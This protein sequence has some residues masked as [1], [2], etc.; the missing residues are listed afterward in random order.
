MAKTSFFSDG[1][2]HNIDTQDFQG[3]VRTLDQRNADAI[4]NNALAVQRATE[5]LEIMAEAEIIADATNVSTTANKTAAQASQAAAL[6]SEVAAQ[7]HRTAAAASE[8]ASATSAATASTKA[9]EAL[10]S[11]STANTAR[12][13]TLAA[14]DVTTG[15]RDTAVTKAADASTSA[16][17]A[18]S[19]ANQLS[20]QL[21]SFNEVYLGKF[22]AAPTLDGNG[23][24]LKV[25]AMYE[26]TTTN[27]LYV[28][29]ADLTWHAYDESAQT[30]TT[31]AALSATNAAGSAAT[32]TASKDTA[33]TQAGI[34]TTKAGEAATSATNAATSATNAAGSATTS[35]TKAGE[36]ATSATNAAN[37]ATTAANT[38]ASKAPLASPQFTGS[39][40]IGL[41]ATPRK[42][43]L[44][45]AQ[46][47]DMVIK[48][49]VASG[50]AG[51]S[52]LYFG[53]NTVDGMGWL[54][55]D[56]ALNS[57]AFATNAG[58]AMRISGA[59]NLLIG[60][61]ADDGASKLQVAGRASIYGAFANA[62]GLNVATTTADSYG[63][64]QVTGKGL[65]GGQVSLYRDTTASGGMFGDST[66]LQLYYNAVGYSLKLASS[67]NVLVGTTTDAGQRLQVIG[68]AVSGAVAKWQAGTDGVRGW[69]Y[70][71]SDGGG[72]G[73]ADLS[74]GIGNGIY[75]NTTGN[76]VTLQTVGSE[77]VR[78]TSG[79]NVL[80]GTT[81][82]NG[83]DKLQ[84][85]GRG[86]FSNGS[87]GSLVLA[88]AFSFSDVNYALKLEGDTGTSGGYLSQ[89]VNVGGFQLSQGGTYYGG[90]PTRTDANSTSFSSI[91][92][93]AGELRF[94]TNSALSVNSNFT[95]A[96][97][98]RINTFG[99]LGL[100]T[101]A[102][103]KYNHGGSARVLEIANNDTAI[104]SQAHLILNS[105]ATM[106]STAIGTMS[107][108]MP[109][110][111]NAAKMMGY[112]GCVTDATHTS[113]TPVAALTFAVRNGGSSGPYEAMRLMANGD[114]KMSNSL[115]VG[116]PNFGGTPGFSANANGSAYIHNAAQANG[117]AWITV[118]RDGVQ[119]GSIAQ[120]GTTGTVYNTTSDYRLKFQQKPLV[121]SGSF[122][123]ALAPKTWVW[124]DGSPGTGFI[125]HEFQAVSPAS[126]TGEK[127]AVDDEGKP[128]YQAMQ[129]SS[130]E[131]MANIIAELQSLRLRVAQLE[132]Q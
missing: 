70:L 113:A 29:Q 77:R 128:K 127:D 119:L 31:N 45:G 21:Y 71:Y 25:G 72:A 13:V 120:T 92:G 48:S 28:W 100:G 6:A 7:G 79:G 109:G 16:A 93:S 75:W 49:N 46:Y 59:R 65:Y 96:E 41:V 124:S 88:H 107:W 42:F 32:A 8:A 103:T 94:F 76:Y 5:A 10:S 66:G 117:W 90:G 84:V 63:L 60:T 64:L 54:D 110:V 19:K 39:V 95:P 26:N 69:G 105:G 122:I 37:S 68:P 47:T 40:M 3:L 20:A 89:Y 44:G 81:T 1:E 114:L 98:V 33:V 14:R 23:N 18:T 97:R 86:R 121:N 126:V 116:A 12:D 112:I 35:T 30:A 73:V 36:A 111:T 34:A 53:N 50:A 27:K 80:I 22:A 132:S 130:A 56:H 9:A 55:Y 104:N 15:A 43:A 78:V 82:D 4:A 108:A 67:G 91:V 24:A 115:L 2:S 118:G 51:G 74:S 102:P 129:A 131:V 87:A 85:S 57:L 101:T 123:D 58:E 11:A 61:T 83:T 62:P 38:L 106:A 99:D 17:T 125:A 52:T